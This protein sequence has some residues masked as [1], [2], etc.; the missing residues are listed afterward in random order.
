MTTLGQQATDVG[1]AHQRGRDQGTGHRFS[2]RTLKHPDVIGLI[3]VCEVC[4]Y[5]R[6][7]CPGRH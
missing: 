5:A 6:M 3:V 4:S 7:R 2:P 1:A